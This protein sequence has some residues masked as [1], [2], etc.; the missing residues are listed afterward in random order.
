MLEGLT[1]KKH[2]SLD[3]LSK[4]SLAERIIA[5]VLGEVA[6]PGSAKLRNEWRR[7]ASTFRDLD[8]SHLQV[9]VLGGG[10]GLSNIV[11]GDS[12]RPEWRETPFTGLKERFPNLHS[13][14]CVTDDGG[15]TGELLKDFPFVALG[16]LRHVLLSAICSKTLQKEYNLDYVTAGQVASVLHGLF[17]YRFISCPLS[18][19]GLIADTAV[20]FSLLPASL[21]SYLRKLLQGLFEND[22]INPSLS[23]PQ[24]LGN[25]LLAAAMYV[26]LPASFD[27]EKAHD[28]QAVLHKATLDGLASLSEAIGAGSQSVLPAT[29]TPAELQVLYANGVLVTSECKSSSGRR[30]YPVD[31]VLVEFVQPPRLPEKV[32]ELVQ[33][34]DIIIMAPGSLYTSII[35]ILQIP[36]LADLIRQNK[37]ALKLLVANIWVQKGET[38]ATRE[39]PQR[40]FHVSDLIRAYD[41]NISGGIRGLFSHVLSLD[42]ADISGAVLQNYALE[43]KE[44]IYLDADRVRQYGLEPVE[45]SIFSRELLQQRNVIQHDPTSFALVVQTLWGLRSGGLLPPQDDD[46]MLPFSREFALKVR[47]DSIFSCQRYKKIRQVLSKISFNRLTAENNQSHAMSQQERIRMLDRLV[48]IVWRHPDVHVDHLDLIQSVCLVDTRC[49]KRCQQWD[50]VFSFYDPAEQAINIRMDQLED[51]N[52]MEMVFIVGVGQSLLGNYARNKQLETIYFQGNEAGQIYSLT[53]QATND[54]DSYFSIEELDRYLQLARMYPCGKMKGVYGRV[55]NGDE[56]F[57]PPGLLFGLM[58]AWYLD[59]L[60]A[61]N[62]DYKMSIMKS[63]LSY[64]IPEQVKIVGR[65]EQLIRFFREIVFR[66]SLPQSSLRV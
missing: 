51:G 40:K 21:A 39:A 47:A 38:D 46:A 60:F 7:I 41:Y 25:L 4:E 61:P 33:Q 59:N 18:V 28:Q 3:F 49:W 52:R 8:P 13:I 34:A 20:D 14:V 10:T 35:P 37:H 24:C 16:D 31:R 64:L 43:Y 2:C 66:Q 32:V 23:R 48:E 9:V 19:D 58:Y 5:L 6:L 22:Q 15:S 11:G 42:L 63:E 44:P 36:G 53:L 54:L 62:I 17:N 1:Q 45:A 65:R 55:V 57:T 27:P 56:G 12:R 29:T 26:K 30:G 50:N